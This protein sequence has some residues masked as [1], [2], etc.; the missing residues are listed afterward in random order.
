MKTRHRK[1]TNKKIKL[2]RR[3]RRGG[4]PVDIDAAIANLSESVKTTVKSKVEKLNITNEIDANIVEKALLI[5]KI[6]SLNIKE[7]ESKILN[8]ENLKKL[9]Q[10][11]EKI[12]KTYKKED[13][14][15]GFKIFEKF[16]SDLSPSQW[17]SDVT[18]P[19]TESITDSIT[20][21]IDTTE[22]GKARELREDNTR[23]ANN[24]CLFVR[25]A[26]II[27]LEKIK[28]K[29]KPQLELV[30][31]SGPDK[32]FARKTVNSIFGVGKALYEV[33]ASIR[34]TFQTDLEAI[35]EASNL[36]SG[37]KRIY[38][39]SDS[40]LV[41]EGG[42]IVQTCVFP[43][44]I[45]YDRYKIATNLYKYA[46]LKSE[47]K[48]TDELSKYEREIQEIQSNYM[49]DKYTPPKVPNSPIVQSSG[50]VT[51]S[52][53]PRSRSSSSDSRSLITFGGST[54]NLDMST[55]NKTQAEKDVSNLNK[56]GFE[57]KVVELADTVGVE[58]DG[59][60]L[61][62]LMD[63]KR[64]RLVVKIGMSKFGKGP[65]PVERD[66]I[67][68]ITKSNLQGILTMYEQ[69][70]QIYSVATSALSEMK[71]EGIESSV[72]ELKNKMMAENVQFQTIAHDAIKNSEKFLEE[73]VNVLSKIKMAARMAT[74]TDSINK[75]KDIVNKA[76]SKVELIK[77]Y[78]ALSKVNDESSEEELALAGDIVKKSIKDI[79]INS[80]AALSASAKQIIQK[81]KS[82]LIELKE[83]SDG[84]SKMNRLTQKRKPVNNAAIAI[85]RSLSNKTAKNNA[86][87]LRSASN[88]IDEAQA[89]VNKFTAELKK[90]KNGTLENKILSA[91][92]EYAESK[93]VTE[94]YRRVKIEKNIELRKKQREKETSNNT[95]LNSDI[96]K[97]ETAKNK[98]NKDYETAYQ[99]EAEKKA[100]LD[101]I[102]SRANDLKLKNTQNIQALVEESIVT[103]ETISK[104]RDML[105]AQT[106][107]LDLL[108]SKLSTGD[109]MLNGTKV[110]QPRVDKMQASVTKLQMKY[111]T[112]LEHAPPELRA[113]Y[114]ASNISNQ[115][116]LTTATG[117]A[118]GLAQTGYDTVSET[119]G[120][121]ATALGKGATALGK[122]ISSLNPFGTSQPA[123]APQG[124]STG[125]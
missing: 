94:T 112:L 72:L 62:I 83:K 79:G 14:P 75:I 104:V 60:L 88:A 67:M 2:N 37:N 63:T 78:D 107:A 24:W 22:V 124:T 34:R 55:V 113:K 10:L 58:L 98:A 53:P 99:T 84:V 114:A 23:H 95:S 87:E 122:G 18:T 81:D 68:D 12:K 51:V 121:G 69:R 125:P 110:T 29:L 101:A 85:N 105:K 74:S 9:K 123:T 43:V 4:A 96:A 46:K 33:P 120:Q 82:H 27:L 50:R 52:P 41:N 61:S 103:T 25:T 93:Y 54:I 49:E 5:C 30:S 39:G 111:N 20:E 19:S 118:S 6:K 92:K 17:I 91:K 28:F 44:K 35:V 97:L 106:G 13:I 71:K 45:A 73:I 59:K 64:K 108:K 57:G 117:L 16:I 66:T 31:D 115:T 76:K 86:N 80:D 90:A 21:F 40:K 119:L 65:K 3:S 36:Y 102:S 26:I 100:A 1:K 70:T 15:N 77:A 89:E 38:K 32:S 56:S 116:G 47:G 7:C 109:P 48:G 42:S 8:K 11:G